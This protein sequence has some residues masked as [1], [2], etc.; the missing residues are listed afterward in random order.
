MPD[1]AT[2]LEKAELRQLDSNFENEI[3]PDTW[4][5]VQFNPESLKVAFANQLQ[6]PSGAGDQ[7]GLPLHAHRQLR[8]ARQREGEVTEAA[9]KIEHASVRGELEQLHRALHQGGIDGGVERVRKGHG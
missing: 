7:R 3:E 2:N 4:C 5:K 8:V 1:A 6:Q 9:E